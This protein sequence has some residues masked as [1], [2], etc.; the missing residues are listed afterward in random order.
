MAQ[1]TSG[2]PQRVGQQGVSPLVFMNRD[3]IAEITACRRK[4]I[5]RGRNSGVYT[6]PP[7]N[8]CALIIF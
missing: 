2:M 5:A 3:G 7:I 8:L 4:P 1:S 6:Q